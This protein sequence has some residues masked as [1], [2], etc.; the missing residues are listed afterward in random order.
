M[1]GEELNEG[2]GWS[3]L[4]YVSIWTVLSY[5][6][7]WTVGSLSLSFRSASFNSLNL[8]CCPMSKSVVCTYLGA[9]RSLVDQLSGSEVYLV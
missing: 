5:V 1:R 3:F 8:T 6:S 4:S 9:E 7:I 2:K